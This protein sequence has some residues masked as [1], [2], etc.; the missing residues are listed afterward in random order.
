MKHTTKITQNVPRDKLH[1]K[2]DEELGPREEGVFPTPVG[3]FLS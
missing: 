3:Q 1:R 2:D